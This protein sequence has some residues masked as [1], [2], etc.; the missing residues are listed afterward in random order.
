MGQHQVALD[1]DEQQLQRYM[2]A[3]LQDLR[4]LEYMIEEDRL[5]TGVVR[6]GAEQE[7]FL[8]NDQLGAAPVAVKCSNAQRN[9]V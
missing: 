3:L 5:E 2:K 9:L 7:M 6:I 8:V 4:A 1:L